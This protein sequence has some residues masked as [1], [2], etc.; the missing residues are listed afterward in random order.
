MA[1]CVRQCNITQVL[2]SKKLLERLP[3]EV[4]G[5]S[6]FLEDI[7]ETVSSK[8]R[9]VAMLIAFIA[10]VLMEERP[11]HGAREMPLWGSLFADADR[12][13]TLKELRISNLAN[14][15]KALQKKK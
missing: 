3:I 2:T 8:D 6:I 11:L 10:L 9:I 7:R 5:Q 15:V 14:Y 1:S 4:P 12:D 13:P